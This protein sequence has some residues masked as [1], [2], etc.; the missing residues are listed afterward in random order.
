[1]KFH[2]F[3]RFEKETGWYVVTCPA[4]PGCASQGR[5]EKEAMENIREAILAWLEVE[6]EKA[7]A[8]ARNSGLEGKEQALAI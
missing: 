8:E 5:S 7:V 3:V 2:V 1:M 6:D 4:L